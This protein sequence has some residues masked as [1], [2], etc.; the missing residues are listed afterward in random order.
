MKSQKQSEKKSINA[1]SAGS[2]KPNEQTEETAII[3]PT[4]RAEAHAW[5]LSFKEVKE[6]WLDEVKGERTGSEKTQAGYLDM[7]IPFVQYMNAT[8][9][10]I[11][12]KGAEE[13]RKEAASTEGL[14]LKTWADRATLAFFNWIQTQTAKKTKKKITRYSA[15]TFY[16]TARSFLRHNGF[17]FKGKTP[18][19]QVGTTTKL[20]SNEQLAEAWKMANTAQK[21]ACGVL[22]STLWRPEDALALIFGDLQDQFDAQRFY[23]EKVTQK[24]ELKVGVYLTAETTEIVRLVMRKRYGDAKPNPSDRVLDY[25]YNNLLTHVQNFG[26]N[27]GLTLSPKYFRKLGR[28]RCAP[29]IGQDA[30]FKMGGWALP[31][32]GKN[33]VLPAPEDTLKCYLQ[34]ENLLTFEP[35]A[36]SDKEQQIE[37]LIIGAMAQGILRPERANE[38]RAVFRTKALTPE[39]AAMEIRK[40]A[41]KAKQ[42][43][44]QPKTATNGDC[45]DGKHC[46][47]IVSEA[48]LEDELAQ[49]WRVAAVLPSGKIVVSNE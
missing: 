12:A 31:G 38:M 34:I 45:P 11:V 7:I 39:E 13:V 47:R 19:A 20:P 9:T 3:I 21:L 22:R 41:E 15:K 18:I 42:N 14:E 40:E 49:G 43:E 4:N 36:V 26:K 29:V 48:E 35:K 32:V 27:V 30:V 25:N 6:N 24:E 8:P 16:G 44:Q 17:T 23:I 10:E 2:L 33:Y 28:T 1:P 46:Q 37:N 5:L